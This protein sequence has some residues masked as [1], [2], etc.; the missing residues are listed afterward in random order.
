MTVELMKAETAG[1]AET[2]FPIIDVQHNGLGDVIVGCWM[3]KSAKLAGYHLMMNPRK[4]SMV[5][6]ML[7][8]GPEHI[9]NAEGKN[10]TETAELGLR[11]EYR[12]QHDKRRTR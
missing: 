9:T 8:I 5:P 2:P 12:C 4:W 6:A 10:W 7:G 11:Y 1:V 3:I